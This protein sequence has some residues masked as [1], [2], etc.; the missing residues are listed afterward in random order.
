MPRFVVS[1]VALDLDGTLLH[2]LPDIAEAAQRML[3]ELGRAEV[4]EARVCS[5]VGNGIPRLVKR[6]LTGQV[7]AEPEPALFE[8]ALQMFQRHYAAT[9]LQRPLPFPGVVE[10]LMRMQAAGL[11]L[12]CVTN[13]ARA[14]TEPLLEAAGL[15]RYFQLVLSGDSLPAK[16]PDP[17][18]LLH[19]ARCFDTAPS[20]VLVIGD[21][22]NDTRAARA[23]GC[24]V[25]CVAYGYRGETPV[26]DL[27]CDAIVN[28]LIE[29][30]RLI[31]VA[32]VNRS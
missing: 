5:Y 15:S 16:K 23:A 21:S 10:G 13:K 7:Q 2:T 14:F 1:A 4:D 22:D 20:Q 28:D 27:D 25:I 32:P 31:D 6:L 3:R 30:Y 29:A 17:L 24:P 12:A 26:R 8:Q 19:V 9:F 11:R 18:P